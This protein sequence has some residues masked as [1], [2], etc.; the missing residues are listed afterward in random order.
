M[1]YDIRFSRSCFSPKP[2]EVIA[3]FYRWVHS[4]FLELSFPWSMNEML[5]FLDFIINF[6]QK[7][8][9]SAHAL[10]ENAVSKLRTHSSWVIITPNKMTRPRV[11]ARQ[12]IVCCDVLSPTTR[13]QVN[14]IKTME[15]DCSR[16]SAENLAMIDGSDKGLQMVKRVYRGLQVVTWG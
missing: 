16:N 11:I 10:T 9:W 5:I 12:E 1:F 13:S 8:S 4:E 7:I 15:S 2:G 6:S 14:K 3:Y